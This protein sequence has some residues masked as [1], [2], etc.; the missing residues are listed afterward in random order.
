MRE[1]ARRDDAPT[2]FR[3]SVALRCNARRQRINGAVRDP[4]LTNQ[5]HLPGSRRGPTDERRRAP[6]SLS[7]GDALPAILRV[8]ITCLRRPG[9][10]RAVIKRIDVDDAPHPALIGQCHGD[11]D[12]APSA[13]DLIGSSKTERI[14]LKL[15]RIGGRQCH[16]R[17]RIGESPRIVLATERALARTKHL[18]AWR[19]LGCQF[20]TNGTA[21]TLTLQEHALVSSA[22]SCAK[23]IGFAILVRLRSRRNGHLLTAAGHS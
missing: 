3:F 19:P 13:D 8:V 5:P 2:S 17:F 6:A 7:S 12:A 15:L 11:I 4:A 10:Q 9:E 1:S 16:L 20:H 18:V 22:E 14:S 21:V 23:G